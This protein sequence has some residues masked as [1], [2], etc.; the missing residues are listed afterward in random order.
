MA[1]QAV[2]KLAEVVGEQDGARQLIERLI[3]G[4]CYGVDELTEADGGHESGCLCHA[5]TLS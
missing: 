2:G 1:E 4:P 5:S 3:V